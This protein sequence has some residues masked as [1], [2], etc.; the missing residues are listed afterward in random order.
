MTATIRR[1]S[2]VRGGRASRRALSGALAALCSWLLPAGIPTASAQAIVRIDGSSSLYP[3]V[4][5]VARDVQLQSRGAV[6]APVHVSGTRGGFRVFCAGLSDLQGASRPILDDEMRT[7][8]AA[9]IEF[10]ELPVA[11][12]AVAIAVHAGNSWARQLTT[13]QLAQLWDRSAEGRLTRWSQ[14]DPSWPDRPIVLHG[15][16]P[17]SGTRDFFIDALLGPGASMRRD[18]A[19]SE[20]DDRI[21]AG[22][23]A[24]AEAVG[25]LPQGYVARSHGRVRALAIAAHG[26]E[27]IEPSDRNVAAARYRPLSRPL[28]V[29]VT[30]DALQRPEVAG[31]VDALLRRAERA[32]NALGVLPLPEQAYRAARERLQQRRVGSA[33]GG[34]S[35]T[36]LSIDLL[37]VRMAAR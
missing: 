8:A 30:S 6:R 18:Y 24:S 14:L 32:G 7:C 17:D 29:Y 19:A 5:A 10:I 28:F 3:L 35:A 9:G 25:I 33:F 13:S 20:D 27:P 1:V 23:A 16:G 22:I 11:L 15:P 37:L 21:V 26:A 36:G 34:G 12:D 31:F 4:E 2:A